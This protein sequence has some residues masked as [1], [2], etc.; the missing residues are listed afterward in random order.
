[1]EDRKG[2]GCTYFLL[3]EALDVMFGFLTCFPR[4]SLVKLFSQTGFPNATVFKTTKKLKG[5]KY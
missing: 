2:S 4:K 1:M 3:V 5:L